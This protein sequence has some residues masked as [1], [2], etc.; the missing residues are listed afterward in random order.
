MHNF[1]GDQGSSRNHRKEFEEAENER[2]GINKKGGTGYKM[3]A[4]KRAKNRK[5]R[6]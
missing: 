6:K 2:N 3:S 1:R 5:K 4:Q